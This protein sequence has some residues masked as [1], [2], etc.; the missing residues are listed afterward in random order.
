MTVTGYDTG[1]LSPCPY[2][3]SA[4]AMSV[5]RHGD[6]F[7]VSGTRTQPKRIRG[8]IVQTSHRQASC[9]T[10][11]IHSTERLHRSQDTEHNCEMGQSSYGSGRERIEYEADPQHAEL[12]IYQLGLRNSSRSVSTPSEKSKPGV[13][14]SSLLNS[15]DHTLYRSATMRLCYLALDR[16]DL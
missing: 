5:F 2:H 16:L 8:T 4:V 6:D 12:I 10:G 14:L 13:D 7:V 1:K 11:T 9:H 15:A 3:S